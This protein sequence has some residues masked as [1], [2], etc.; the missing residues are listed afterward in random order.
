MSYSKSSAVS[1]KKPLCKVCKD[2]GKSESEYTSHYV[3]SAPV[4]TNGIAGKTVV[5]CP[6]LLS[7]E[8]R[9]CQELGHIAKY[10]PVLEKNERVAEFATEKCAVKAPTIEKKRASS[11]FAILANENDADDEKEVTQVSLAKPPIAT[12][13]HTY[14]KHT[15]VVIPSP[16]L[17]ADFPALQGSMQSSIR[18]QVKTGFAT[19]VAKAKAPIEDKSYNKFITVLDAKRKSNFKHVQIYPEEEFDEIIEIIEVVKSPLFKHQNWA[20]YSD[21]DSESELEME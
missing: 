4:Y 9:Y 16:G 18:R 13:K 17:E 12:N 20:D 6:T 19:M 14:A 7:T 2:A 8:C 10:C 1:T 11:I 21:T 5:I 3:R 15:S